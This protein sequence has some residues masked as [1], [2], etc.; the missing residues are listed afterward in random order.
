MSN[1]MIKSFGV[2]MYK[3]ILLVNVMLFTLSVTR[4]W[5][6][7]TFQPIFSP[8]TTYVWIYAYGLTHNAKLI[9]PYLTSYETTPIV[10]TLAQIILAVF[11]ILSIVTLFVKSKWGPRVIGAIGLIYLAWSLGFIPVIYEGTGRAPITG[12]R[13]PVQGQIKIHADID[14][15]I[16]TASFQDGYYL[17]IL[18]SIIFI[19]L[20]VWREHGY[21][22]SLREKG[23]AQ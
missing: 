1:I 6:I 12:E 16:I 18:S 3:I 19:L 14:E 17:A 13:F 20:F 8:D 23:R 9:A 10:M 22:K 11:A 21:R 5:W 15:L 7:A 4:P 2:V